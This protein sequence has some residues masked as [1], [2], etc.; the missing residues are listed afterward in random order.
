[1]PTATTST[2][3]FALG[4]APL[5]NRKGYYCSV[6][7]KTPDYSIELVGSDGRRALLVGD[8]IYNPVFDGDQPT[9][10]EGDLV[11]PTREAESRFVGKYRLASKLAKVRTDY[12]GAC[13]AIDPDVGATRA[14][15]H[16]GFVVFPGPSDCE[17][18]V[19]QA[20]PGV[21]PLPLLPS[22]EPGGSGIEADSLALAQLEALITAGMKAAKPPTPRSVPES[23]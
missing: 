18:W 5:W 22:Q 4:W 21:V 15:E 8:C 23:A 12:A 13:F 11:W 1:M 10:G 14:V 6:G 19:S 7:F 3:E 20:S 17:Q 16:L 9:F 2:F